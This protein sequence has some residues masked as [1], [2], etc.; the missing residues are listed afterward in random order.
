MITLQMFLTVVV[1]AADPAAGTLYVSD[2]DHGVLIF[3]APA[4]AHQGQLDAAAGIAGPLGIAQGSDGRLYVASEQTDLVPCFDLGDG[5]YIG[6][7]IAHSGLDEPSS[8]V[9]ISDRTGDGVEELLVASFIGDSVHLFD[10]ATGEYLE[11][12]VAA[13]SGGL[14]GPDA[15]MVIGPDGNLYVPSYW[16]NRILRYDGKTGAFIDVFVNAGVGGLAR[17]RTL[18]FR[19][20]GNLV[21]SCES[22]DRV[23]VY[24]GETGA[25][26]L[27][28]F[29]LDGPTG[30]AL[31]GAG[32]LY[33]ASINGS[34]VGRYDAMTGQ[35]DAVVIPSGTAG[36]SLPTFV[37]FTPATCAE[38]INEDGVIGFADLISMLENWGP[39]GGGAC[40][41]DLDG[42]GS[43]DFADLLQ[44]LGAWG[45]CS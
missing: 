15:G 34:S 36:L 6:N 25:Y 1:S 39:C 43:V 30:M 19:D 2:Y 23:N 42:S 29:T 26:M 12:F 27:R 16:S 44:V 21:V 20:D 7:F 22:A 18:L 28:L 32:W 9:F 8:L 13:G 3:D 35:L 40:P 5:T 33:V 17:P 38:D 10:G 24:D 14:N 37:Y 41:A 11:D 31:D 4:G 45:P